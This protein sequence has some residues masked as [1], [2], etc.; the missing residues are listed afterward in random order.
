M[1]IPPS[2]TVEPE[3][4]ELQIVYED[5]V[6]CVI[7]KPAGL[8]VHPAPGHAGGTLVNA[9]VHR[10]PTLDGSGSVRPGLVHRLDKD[11]SG[12]MVVGLT[13]EA[14]ASLADQVKAR[15]MS[16]GYVALV[17][18]HVMPNRAMID[19]PVGRD[20]ISRKR[21]AAGPKAIRARTA[22]THYEVN[23]LVGSLSLICVRLETGR[24]HQIRVHM[25]YIGHPVA[26]DTLYKGPAL[27]GLH[28]QFLHARSLAFTHP[29]TGDK[30]QFQCEM[31]SDLMAV[32]DRLRQLR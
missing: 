12:L 7:D 25:A 11:T 18:G 27:P 5:E 30:V 13:A 16:R 28:R 6:V 2:L 24:T 8:V 17:Q 22:V 10:F 32:L 4:I 14:Q 23:E 15:S 21:M 9:L 29:A 26:G 1:L 20:P 19:I 31:P 3:A